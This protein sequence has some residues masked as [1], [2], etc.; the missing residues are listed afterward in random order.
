MLANA[1]IRY[2]GSIF[3]YKC[4]ERDERRYSVGV[5]D[6]QATTDYAYLFRSSLTSL[7]FGRHALWASSML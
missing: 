4:D 7:Y 5:K 1:A 6:F 2:L 3:Q